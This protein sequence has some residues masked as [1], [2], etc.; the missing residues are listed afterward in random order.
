MDVICDGHASLL[1]VPARTVREQ[2]R[3]LRGA[4]SVGTDAAMLDYVNCYRQQQKALSSRKKWVTKRTKGSPAV[5]TTAPVTG[6]SVFAPRNKEGL[7]KE[8]VTEDLTATARRFGGSKG[9]AVT[10]LQTITG[11]RMVVQ[12]LLTA[13]TVVTITSDVGPVRPV[14]GPS[15]TVIPCPRAGTQFTCVRLMVP[16]TGIGIVEK[17]EIYDCKLHAPILYN[18]TL[19]RSGPDGN[20]QSEGDSLSVLSARTDDALGA[21]HARRL[22][23]SLLALFPNH[24]AAELV[25]GASNLVHLVKLVTASAATQ[26]PKQTA[27]AEDTAVMEG[28][29]RRAL[30]RNTKLSRLVVGE[31]VHNMFASTELILQVPDA[32]EDV[33]QPRAGSMVDSLHPPVPGTDWSSHVICEGARA[34]RVVFD[35][36]SCLPPSAKQASLCFYLSQKA[37]DEDKDAFKI[38]YGGGQPAMTKTR[39]KTTVSPSAW[40]RQ[41]VVQSDQLWFRFR[42]NSRSP[43]GSAGAG[44]PVSGGLEMLLN[45]P[46]GP[47]N[48]FSA[49]PFD[50]PAA[51]TGGTGDATSSTVSEPVWG[52]RFLV[53]PVCGL[54]W[55][56]EEQVQQQPS[57][58]WSCWTMQL[59]LRISYLS[60]PARKPCTHGRGDPSIYTPEMV[61]V[62]AKYLRSSDTPFKEKIVRLLT[63]LLVSA[64]WGQQYILE[65]AASELSQRNSPS[66]RRSSLGRRQRTPK[67]RPQSPS[68]IH[69]DRA[70][71]LLK[72]LHPEVRNVLE[73]ERRK[74]KLFVEPALQQLAEL[75][76][77]ATAFSYRRNHYI[78]YLTAPQIA[79]QK[80]KNFLQSM[81]SLFGFKEKRRGL[82]PPMVIARPPDVDSIQLVRAMQLTFDIC[83]SLA[84]RGRWPDEVVCLAWARLYPFQFQLDTKLES[85]RETLETRVL[86][87][88]TTWTKAM[89]VQLVKWVNVHCDAEGVKP[90]KLLPKNLVQLCANESYRY[91]FNQIVHLSQIRLRFRL[92]ILQTFNSLVARILFLV[93]F[94]DDSKDS[95]SGSAYHW[96]LGGMLNKLSWA[97]FRESKTVLLEQAV[98]STWTDVAD[99]LS[100]RLNNNEAFDSRERGRLDPALSRCLF[101]QTFH[102]LS[103]VRATRLCAKL[104]KKRAIFYSCFTRY[105]LCLFFLR[106]RTRNRVFY[107]PLMPLPFVLQN[108]FSKLSSKVKK[109]LTGAG[110]TAKACTA[111]WKIFSLVAI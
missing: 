87:D 88:C 27:E 98:N 13:A 102:Q 77:A 48:P 65:N 21:Q 26:G 73:I 94:A 39:Q 16:E 51:T 91:R 3:A 8:P 97:I 25:G 99:G 110:Y 18:H 33:G 66:R 56:R 14:V 80:T 89:D 46:P 55:L 81:T 15:G 104:D 61:E 1:N 10:T 19:R 106:A 72:N 36:R 29:F 109:D 4:S 95:Q 82:V 17:Y 22:T 85:L 68:D 28:I 50:N 5:P 2:R 108:A 103:R 63:Q 42:C 49:N 92:A 24:D 76:S 44:A 96:S 6:F 62:L 35:E 30:S 57:L 47:P 59:L 74:G 37:L 70:M 69:L 86:D 31:C 7:A 23:A 43:A 38:I 41:F 78:K 45:A 20:P 71:N 67:Q 100:V 58:Q 40:W 75:A 101:T 64:E 84:T 83:R 111:V 34:L 9:P 107:L 79:Q 52:F 54:Q 105:F 11:D 60:L 93:N 32:I 53:T 12:S 90:E